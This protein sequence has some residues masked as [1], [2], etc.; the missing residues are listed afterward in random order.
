[1]WHGLISTLRR[2][3]VV[4]ADMNHDDLQDA[5]DILRLLAKP[6]VQAPAVPNPG[7]SLKGIIQGG[8]LV[9]SC[10]RRVTPNE[11]SQSREPSD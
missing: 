10:C 6:G 1:M 4:L 9:E 5:V 11:I 3:E 2:H 8:F 7:G